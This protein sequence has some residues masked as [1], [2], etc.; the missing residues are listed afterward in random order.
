MLS[1]FM[2][3]IPPTPRIYKNLFSYAV[4]AYINAG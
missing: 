3:N 4:F 1:I 2:S